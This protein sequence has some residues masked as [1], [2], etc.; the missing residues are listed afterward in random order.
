M[1]EFKYYAAGEDE[2]KAKQFD[3]Y[4]WK[5]Q[6]GG[7]PG[8]AVQGVVA[9]LGVTQ[10]TTASGSIVVG[11]GLGI[12]QGT[13]TT[14]VDRLNNNSDKTIDVLGASPM[15][16][17][18][19][20]DIVVFN[21]ATAS[22]SVLVGT[23]N[24]SPT[25]PSYAGMLPLARIRNAASA[26]TIPTSAIDDLRVFTTLNVPDSPK[27]QSW[28]ATSYTNTASE[29]LAVGNGT[30]AG[31]WRISGTG[32]Q[33]S[34]TFQGKLTRGTTTNVGTA[35]ASWAITLPTPAVDFDAVGV[36]LQVIGSTRKPL[37]VEMVNSTTIVFNDTAG[38][39]IGASNPGGG[40]A[41]QDGHVYR[42]SITYFIA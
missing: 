19:R 1:S 10:T 11:A 7:A 25:D 37:A 14:G 33:Q 26:T 29:T 17:L 21:P 42:W 30:L 39:R 32:S 20:N 13:I 15:G 36:G 3:A 35:G 22:T 8:F 16:A 4:L 23:P 18:P 31:R 6:L 27:W 41:A 24:A 5:Q 2:S 38:N 28:S 9:G 34:V 12:Y 40:A